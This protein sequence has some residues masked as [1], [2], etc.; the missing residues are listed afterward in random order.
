V[1]PDNEVVKIYDFGTVFIA[2]APAPGVTETGM[3]VGTPDYF[4]PEQASAKPVG[5]Q[6]DLYACGVIMYLLATGQLPFAG[7][8]ALD[9]AVLHATKPPEKPSH[10]SR[11]IDPR[12]ERIIL[13]CLAKRPA[14]RPASAIDLAAMLAAIAEGPGEQNRSLAPGATPPTRARRFAALWGVL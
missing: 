1:V 10:F 2:G 3:V 5:P 9:L 8:T 14:D 13:Q 12:L 7:K 4:S 11:D 6:T